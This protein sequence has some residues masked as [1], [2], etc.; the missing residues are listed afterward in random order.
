MGLE[1]DVVTA[2]IRLLESGAT[3]PFIARYRKDLT[4]GL[5]DAQ[6]EAIADANNYFI[7]VTNRR[8]TVLDA[9]EKQG[10]LTDELRQRIEQCATKTEL[11]DIY[12]PFKPKRKNKATQAEEQGLTPLADFIMKQLPVIQSLEEHTDSFVKSDK[13]ILSPEMALE[14]ARYI[15]AERFAV[16]P[17]ARSTMRRKM[18]EEGTLTARATKNAE[19]TKTKYE[20]YYGFSEPV[21]KVPSHRMLAIL[22]GVKEGLL[23]IDVALDDEATFNGLLQQYV[24]TAGSIFEPHIRLALHEA[25]TRHLRPSIENDVLEAMRKRADDD[26][27][28]VFRQNA[29]NLLLGPPAGAV[30]V[31]GVVALGKGVSACKV[32]VV[33]L[34]GALI[35]HQAVSLKPEEGAETPQQTLAGLIEQYQVG[36]V[37]IGNSA[38]SGEI[39]KI[40]KAVLAEAVKH[41]NGSGQRPV[42]VSVSTAPAAS[43]ASSKL[44]REE[45]PDLESSVREAVSIARRI[46]DPL[47][48]LVKVEPRSVGVGQYQHDVNQKQLR[49]GLHHTVAACVNRVGVDLNR[50]PV[51]LLRYVSG[52]QLGTAQNIVNARTAAGGL[53][54]RAQLLEIDGIGSRV[55]EQCAGFMRI[56]GG[57]NPLDATSIHPEAYG[58]VEQMAASVGVPVAELLGNRELVGKIDFAAFQTE[59]FG[60]LTMA[61]IRAELIEPGRDVRSKFK[62]PKLIEG[63]ASIADLQEGMSIEGV[64]TNVTD[65]GAFIDIGVQQDG[66]VHLSELSNRFVKDPREIIKVGDVVN[67]KVIKVDKDVPRISLSIKALHVPRPRRPSRPRVNRAAAPDGRDARPQRADAAA[68]PPDGTQESRPRREDQPRRRPQR[69][70]GGQETRRPRVARTSTPEDERGRSRDR[71]S[72]SR[73]GEPRDRQDREGRPP[74]RHEPRERRQPIKQSDSGE[75]INTLLADQL[76]ALRDKFGG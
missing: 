50:S 64:V 61:D 31:I 62:A 21:S 29:Q 54:S 14:G 6:I 9:I 36:V 43:Y 73:D 58:L 7:G 28:R 76:A 5:D 4:G 20:S 72:R 59:V 55:F 26:A 49:E 52:I 17:H 38:A 68:A 1:Q 57:E 65:F 46:Q 11:E 2:A 60:P 8:H 44:G 71:E 15:L 66:L 39:V 40:V 13:G 69:S 37:G 42:A 22:R 32:A 16:D 33:D 18:L 74:R 19:G 63:V 70:E 35:H 56:P 30:N 67:V 34:S 25:Y 10:A 53:K 51:T 23:R 41:V 48:E 45:F 3:V 47:A 24:A 75:R 12:L 27:I